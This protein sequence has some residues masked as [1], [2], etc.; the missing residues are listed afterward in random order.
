MEK[1]VWKGKCRS[2]QCHSDCLPT[3]H[4]M[5]QAALVEEV[6]KRQ[7]AVTEAACSVLAGATRLILRGCDFKLPLHA[8]F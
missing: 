4:K 5:A 3:Q 2:L 6:P 1:H 8:C 7:V